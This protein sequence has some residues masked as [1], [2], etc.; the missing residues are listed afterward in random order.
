MLGGRLS[1]R[2]HHEEVSAGIKLRIVILAR[3]TRSREWISAGIVLPWVIKTTNRK[4]KSDT[5]SPGRGSVASMKGSRYHVVP[6]GVRA[7]NGCASITSRIPG[8]TQVRRHIV[9]SVSD[10]F[11]IADSR[12]AAIGAGKIGISSVG[13]TERRILKHRACL[14]GQ[15]T[16][17]AEIC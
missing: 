14:A 5:W 3:D 15:G 4:S 9:P 7:S 1:I 12:I 13:Q 17:H 6:D 2:V 10:A 8:E 16:L 11:R